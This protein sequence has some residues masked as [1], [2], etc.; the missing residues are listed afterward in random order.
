MNNIFII[1]SKGYKKNYGGWETFT[2][3]FCDNYDKKDN[4]IFVSEL[5]ND[6]NLKEYKKDNIVCNPIYTKNTGGSTMMIYSIK[7]LYFYLKYIKQNKLSNCIFLILGLKMGPFLKILKSRIK[8]L[9]IKVFVNPDGL[10]WKRSK[11]SYPIKKFFLYEEKVMLKNCDGIVCDNEGIKTYFEKTY[12]NNKVPKYFIAYGTDEI[13]IDNLNQKEILSE[14]NLKK[15]NYLLV[16]GRCVPENNFDLIIKEFKKSKT[17]K[18]LVIISNTNNDKYYE[19]LKNKY[20]LDN[21]KKIK[22]I[23]GVY[24][25]QKLCVIRKNAFLYI[26]GH[27]VGGTNPSLL[28]AMNYT[29]LNILYNVSFNK[30]VGKNTCLYFNDRENNLKKLL[31]DDVKLKESKKL[32]KLAKERIKENY[33]WKIIIK[34]YQ[35]LFKGDY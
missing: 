12:P 19:E 8:K 15:D 5:T 28:E 21:Y 4:K 1:G 25:K 24:D 13:N 30:E 29:D 32:G 31:D 11:W 14:F 20:N 3:N 16:V 9:N 17:K 34:K 6:K 2:K 22:I 27:S 23:P 18:E 10:E 26:H 33:T 7:T 35:D